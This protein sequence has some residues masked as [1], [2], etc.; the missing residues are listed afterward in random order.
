MADPKEQIPEQQTGVSSDTTAEQTFES[1]AEAQAFFEVVKQRLLQVNKWH[2]WGGTGT[3]EFALT[4]DRGNEV[5]RNPQP[6]DHFRIDIPGP[7]PNTGDGYDWVRVEAVEEET[8]GDRNCILIRVRPASNP[9]N[10]NPD[11]AHF[12]DDAATSNFLVQRNGTVVS[13]E[14]HGRNEKPNF[15]AEKM[16]DKARNTAVATG[17][18]TA[19]SKLQWKALVNGL[20]QR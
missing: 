14:V 5:R 10:E 16:V 6:G 13:A 3:A 12:F 20:V 9:T 11:V 8:D 19:F 1:A 7:G 15:S 18:V 2:E 17:A 4:D